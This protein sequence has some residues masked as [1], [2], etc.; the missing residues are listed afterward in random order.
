MA[1]GKSTKQ[2]TDAA[3]PTSSMADIAFLLIIFFMVS[4]TF[5]QDKTTVHLPQSINRMEIPKNAT[6]ISF[7]EDGQLR[8]RGQEV[9]M[10]DIEPEARQD[11]SKNTEHYFILKID[12][13]VRYEIVDE[14]LEQ[15]RRAEARNLS[16]P[17]EQEIE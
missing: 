15:L 1:F 2:K 13:T 14:I 8:M 16:F 10:L 7:T 12:K 3:I 11:L 5:S 6:I 9:T 17:T 4:T